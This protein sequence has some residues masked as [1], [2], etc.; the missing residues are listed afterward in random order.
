VISTEDISCDVT[1]QL[2]T[3]ESIFYENGQSIEFKPELNNKSFPFV[4]EYWIE[5]LFGKVV[6]PKINTTNTNEKS[7]KT[8]IEEQDRVLFLNAVVYSSCADSDLTNN[9]A[10][11]IFIVKKIDENNG[12]DLSTGSENLPA[13]STINITKVSETTSFGEL[14]ETEIQIYKAATEKYSVSVWAEKNG[15]EIS[16][17]SKIHLKNKNTLYKFMLPVQIEPNC[18][19]KIEDGKAQL[20]VEGLG[21]RTEKEFSLHGINDGLCPQKESPSSTS[22]ETNNFVKIIDLPA[23]IAAGENV[24]VQLEIRHDVDQE[25]EAWSY[26]YHGSKCYSCAA[27]KRDENKISFSVDEDETKTVKMLVKT[28][29]DIQEGE[30]NLMIKYKKAE[31]KTEKSISEKIVVKAK[32][33]INTANQSVSLLSAPEDSE[34]VFS[35][36]KI[37]ASEWPE[38]DGI[39]VYESTA[40]QTKN[41][42]SWFLAVALGLVGLILAIKKEF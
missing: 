23:E 33:M 28:D 14:L 37:R 31:Q 36:R 1:L 27:G 3:N 25:F 35:S 13:N 30:Y 38:Y 11:K 24:P 6:K 41:L 2:K 12:E 17:K 39:V 32:E 7:W 42:I 9:A 10:Q 20:I 8:N 26:L 18:D 5:D 4:I 22:S 15:K 29:A 40:G 34:S 16:E 21:L 19:K